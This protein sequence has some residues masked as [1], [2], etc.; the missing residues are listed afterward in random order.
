LEQHEA[1]LGGPAKESGMKRTRW[2]AWAAAAVALGTLA[3]CVVA[4]VGPPPPGYYARGYVY[5]P[6]PPPAAV[7][8]PAPPPPPGYWWGRPRYRY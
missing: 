5:G 8:V 2:I 7:V 4:P 6:P 1:A 3:G